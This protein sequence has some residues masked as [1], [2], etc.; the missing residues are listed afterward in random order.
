MGST[1]FTIAHDGLISTVGGAAI[2]TTSSALLDGTKVGGVVRS[3]SE[4]VE[5]VEHAQWGDMDDMPN[6]LKADLESSTVVTSGM[7]VASKVVYGGGVVYGKITVDNGKRN[8][9]Y[10]YDAVIERWLRKNNFAKQ[11]FTIFYD[12]SFTGNAFPLFTKSTDGKS[13]ARVSTKH[14]RSMF[15]RLSKVNG[16]GEHAHAFVNPDFGTNYY[17]AENTKKY[18]CAP[19]YGTAEW[20]KE[21]IKPGESFIFP[22]KTVDSGRQNYS[23]PDWNSARTS[24]WISIGKSVAALN[25]AMM[26]NSMRPLWHIEIH[27]DFWANMYGK[28]AWAAYAPAQKLEKIKEFQTNL[29]N[30][31]LGVDNAGAYI[32]SHMPY[33]QGVPEKAFSLLKITP[34]ENKLLQGKDGFYLTTSREVSQHA[35]V[36]LGLD[37]AMLGTMPG[38]GGMGAGSGSNNRVAFNQRVLLSKADQDMVLN[39]MYMIG[40]VNGWDEDYEWVIEQGLITT[41]DAGA[42][43]QKTEPMANGEGGVNG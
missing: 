35:V 16:Y 40:D 13:I 23:M 39:F 8:W 29:A 34:L 2:I 12:L 3:S 32:A 1:S 28:D 26:A 38:D 36:S 33:E 17:N 15:T 20:I 27:V 25:K 43:A 6:L 7:R 41:L 31:L 5:T 42:E 19:E 10:A 24:N 21:N 18:K 22:L 37:S 11:L 30:T 14:T 4:N 9:H